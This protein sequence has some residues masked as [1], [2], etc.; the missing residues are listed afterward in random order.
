MSRTYDYLVENPGSTVS[1]ILAGIGSTT[2]D[3]IRYEIK[4]CGEL[5]IKDDDRPA[6]Y[7]VAQ[8][9]EQTPEEDERGLE[10]AMAGAKP[11]RKIL[12]P[13]PV[14]NKMIATAKEAGVEMKYNR[15]GRDWGFTKKKHTEFVPSKELPDIREFGFD[16]WLEK[17]FG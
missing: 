14:I 3:K 6:R 16:K 12:N 13:Q 8:I 15:K 1:E 10:E 4:K 2:Q 17:N 9:D 11:K 5:L 7:S